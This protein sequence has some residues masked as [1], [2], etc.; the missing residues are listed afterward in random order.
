MPASCSGWW[1]VSERARRSASSGVYLGVCVVR[2]GPEKRTYAS[3][4]VQAEEAAA[5]SGEEA[6]SGSEGEGAEEEEEEEE[7][8]KARR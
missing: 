7:E 5:G 2:Q 1:G 6:A 8:K 4:T 3:I